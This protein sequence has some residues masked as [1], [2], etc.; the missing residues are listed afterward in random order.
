LQEVIYRAIERDPKNRYPNAREFAHDL[1]HLDQV[2]VA[3][4]PELHDWKTRRTPWV[5]KILFYIFI[6]L[7]PVVII[8]LLFYFAKR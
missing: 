5:R 4:R 1:Q 3:E 2:G 7:I 6:A 8:G